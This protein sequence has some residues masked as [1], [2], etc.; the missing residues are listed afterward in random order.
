MIKT[1]IFVEGQTELV[2][3]REYLLKMFDYQNIDIECYTLFTDSNFQTT[4]Y[5]FPN[6]TATHHFL[7]MN[8]GND[9]AVLSRLLNREQYLWNMGFDRIIGL[10]DMYSKAYREEVQGS[11]IVEDVNQLFISASQN[12][13]NQKAKMAHKIN[14][15]Y[16]IMEAEAWILGFSLSF[17]EMN[18]T[19]TPEYIQ[20]KLGY[21]LREIDPETT[22]FHP[23][24][25]ISDI[26]QLVNE[27][28]NKSK[29]N[30]NAIMGRLQK[31]DFINLANSGKCQS[32]KKFQ[33]TLPMP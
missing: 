28:Y 31:D 25:Q 19:L 29:G 30:I 1:A 33:D 16:A 26:Y 5:P 12:E 18:A 27:N 8:V 14:F 32:F 21:D 7:L 11:I 6:E 22:F 15:Q 20:T 3:V 2:F 24:N 17:Q 9:N 10:R 13:V 23:A 4:E